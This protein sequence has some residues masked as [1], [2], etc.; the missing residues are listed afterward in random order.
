MP[1]PTLKTLAGTALTVLAVL[2]VIRQCRKPAWWPGRLF[3]WI[4]NA[5]HAGVTTWGL[6]HVQIERRFTILDV[7]CG[8]GRT[9]HTLARVASEGKVHGIDYSAASV[10]ASRRTNSQMIAAGRVEIRQSTVSSLP[11]PDGT[12]DLV[13]A[14]ETHYYW[15]NPPED[16]REIL[17]VLKPG[18]KLVLIAETYK[19]MRFDFVYRLAMG[20]LR[21]TYLSVREHNDLLTSAGYSEV[22]IFEERGKGWICGVARRPG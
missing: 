10:A 4:M 2:V 12:F 3:L 11:F 1:W 16:L 22:Q 14:V 6:S 8:G 5:R 18:G 13:T 21:A 9:V 15:P 7:G 17:R 20:L 19:S